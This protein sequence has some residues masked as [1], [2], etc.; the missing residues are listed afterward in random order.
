MKQ[1]TWWKVYVKESTYH[2]SI[3]KVEEYSDMALNI[4]KNSNESIV[5]VGVIDRNGSAIGDSSESDFNWKMVTEISNE[6]M[7]GGVP[8]DLAAGSSEEGAE[9]TGREKTTQGEL[10]FAVYFDI[11]GVYSHMIRQLYNLLI[12]IFHA[13]N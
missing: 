9:E 11:G 1:H 12:F 10:C 7:Q 4:E 3:Q 8:K 13:Q 2:T 6:V 5:N